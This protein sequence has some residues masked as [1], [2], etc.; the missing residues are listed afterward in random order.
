[1]RHAR[2]AAPRAPGR[3]AW[4]GAVQDNLAFRRA[5]LVMTSP[6]PSAAADAPLSY[7]QS[8]VNYELIDPLK[9]AAR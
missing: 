6:T 5:R 7:E 3:P 8:G 1:M 4:R 2:G 9:V